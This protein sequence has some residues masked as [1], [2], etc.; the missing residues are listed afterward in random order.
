[1]YF[2]ECSCWGRACP[3][4]KSPEIISHLVPSHSQRSIGTLHYCH[5]SSCSPASLP[6]SDPETIATRDIY[7][8]SGIGLISVYQ[9]NLPSV[10][11]KDTKK[12]GLFAKLH[13]QI[14]NIIYSIWLAG[15]RQAVVY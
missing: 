2:I 7:F 4:K 1:M 5:D 9:I 13:L 11:S 3:N 10:Q 8:L 6:N 15:I 14:L 12:S